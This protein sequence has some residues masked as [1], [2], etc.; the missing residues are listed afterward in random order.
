MIIHAFNY[1]SKKSTGKK[2]P[3]FRVNDGAIK[4]LKLTI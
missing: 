2:D 3:R 1:A 4:L